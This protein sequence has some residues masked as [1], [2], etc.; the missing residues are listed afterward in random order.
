MELGAGQHMLRVD[1]R[2]SITPKNKGFSEEFIQAR[3]SVKRREAPFSSMTKAP[4]LFPPANFT[5]TS[6]LN[7]PALYSN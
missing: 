3:N 4:A 6:F 2:T 5:P 1:G 7:T